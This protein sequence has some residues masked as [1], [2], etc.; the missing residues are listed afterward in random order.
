MCAHVHICSGTCELCVHTYT[1]VHAHVKFS[2]QCQV[3]FSSIALQFIFLRQVLSLL[4]WLAKKPQIAP[5]L[6]LPNTGIAGVCC[7]DQLFTRVLGIQTQVIRLA[8]TAL[9][10]TSHLPIP[11][12]YLSNEERECLDDEAEINLTIMLHYPSI[13][14][15]QIPFDFP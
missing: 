3:W 11:P 6:Y 15:V 1:Y 10:P 12:T 8:E 7:H 4:D 14:V 5:S 2:S 13:A 9:H